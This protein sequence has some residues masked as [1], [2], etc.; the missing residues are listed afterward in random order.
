MFEYSNLSAKSFLEDLNRCDKH[1]AE[2]MDGL[3]LRQH[4]V[5]AVYVSPNW[6][7][8]N[9]VFLELRKVIDRRSVQNQPRKEEGSITDLLK[10]FS[11]ITLFIFERKPRNRI[12]GV[13][14]QHLC[15]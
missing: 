11:L 14:I 3:K 4:S 12:S 8:D 2:E 15:P 1:E 13:S 6:L 10:W 5:Y 9:K 7:F